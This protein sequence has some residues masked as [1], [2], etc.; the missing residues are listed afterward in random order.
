MAEQPNLSPEKK[1]EILQ[2]AFEENQADRKF[3]RERAWNTV[4]AAVA[5]LIGLGSV[6]VFREATVTFVILIIGV[7]AAGTAYLCIAYLRYRDV[8]SVGLNLQE[9]LGFFEKDF[10]LKGRTIVP[11]ELQ[12]IQPRLGGLTVFF[13]VL[14]WV[15]ACAVAAVIGAGAGTSKP[16]NTAAVTLP[17]QTPFQSTMTSTAHARPSNPSQQKEQ[18]SLPSPD[19]WT[20]IVTG[21]LTAAGLFY[22]AKQLSNSKKIAK[23]ELLLSLYGVIGRYNDIHAKLVEGGPW[24]NGTSGPES[25]RD[26]ARIDRYMG[27]FETIQIFVR[28]GIIDMPTVDRQYSHRVVALLKNEPITQRNLVERE[29]RWGDFIELQHKLEKQPCFKAVMSRGKPDQVQAR[30]TLAPAPPPRN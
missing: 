10:Y 3:W 17:A 20:L 29:Y 15:A 26:W 11:Q 2:A 13:G 19:N 7:W 9:A 22:T 24:A 14:F 1:V 30:D 23:A 21:I 27:L 6:S 25:Q 16:V 28:D 18:T 8:K 12:R 4:S 5:A